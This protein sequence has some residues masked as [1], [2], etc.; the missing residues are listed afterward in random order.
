M[1]FI[2]LFDRHIKSV[3]AVNGS[4]PEASFRKLS[5]I[6]KLM[7]SVNITGVTGPIIFD[8]ILDRMGDPQTDGC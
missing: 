3:A 5:T 7:G 8:K 2:H 1:L 6:Q 4:D